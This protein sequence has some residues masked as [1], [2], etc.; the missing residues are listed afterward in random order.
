MRRGAARDAPRAHAEHSA[1]L[2]HCYREW[3]GCKDDGIMGCPVGRPVVH[4][5][6]AIHGA[7]IGLQRKALLEEEEEEEEENFTVA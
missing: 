6:D 7:T 1:H 2:T 4:A 5:Q 3:N